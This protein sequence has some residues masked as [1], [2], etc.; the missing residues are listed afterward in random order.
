M[1]FLFKKIMIEN[2]Y[3]LL[4]QK[5]DNNENECELLI[6]ASCNKCSYRRKFYQDQLEYLENENDIIYDLLY[7]IEKCYKIL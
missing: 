3:S 7:N 1:S 5:Y 2:W 6:N 4:K